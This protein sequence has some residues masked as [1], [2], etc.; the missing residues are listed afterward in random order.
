MVA[1]N[2]LLPLRDG[3]L[4]TILSTKTDNVANLLTP[5]KEREALS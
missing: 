3:Q 4:Y 5:M 1:V 2:A